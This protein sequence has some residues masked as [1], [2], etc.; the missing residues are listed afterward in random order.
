[1]VELHRDF[2]ILDTLY[3]ERIYE[4]NHDKVIAFIR[5][6]LLFIFNF[7]PTRSFTDYG[8]PLKGKFRV[9]IDSD[10]P[11]FGGFDRFDRKTIYTS[12]RKAE[13][14]ALN[15]P[16]YLYLYLPSRTALVFKKEAI[17]KATEI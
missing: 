10:D 4:N 13:G 17:R 5:G 2:K 7:H 11:A 14:F 15:V 6:D 12:V 3:I 1:M 9:I 8:I 16:F